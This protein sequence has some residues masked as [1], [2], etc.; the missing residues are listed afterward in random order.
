MIASRTILQRYPDSGVYLL[1]SL[2]NTKYEFWIH[3]RVA[4]RLPR[5]KILRQLMV[6]NLFIFGLLHELC[7]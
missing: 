3:L 7:G 4:T 1:N 2:M 6:A 5:K